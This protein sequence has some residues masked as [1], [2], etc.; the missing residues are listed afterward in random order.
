[1]D[2]ST[3][4]RAVMIARRCYFYFL[5]KVIDLLDT[6]FFVLRKKQN[7][8]T[9]LHV[10]HHAGMVALSWSGTKYFPG[11]HSVFM[12]MLN[13]FVH[14]VMYFY[15]FLTSLSPKYKQNLWWKKH[16]T[17]LQIVSICFE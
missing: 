17:Q 11:G 10:Y 3:R 4:P 2:F 9:F 6:V 7:Q 15:Y 13:S 16:I 1:V 8:V 5:I 12:G 14:V